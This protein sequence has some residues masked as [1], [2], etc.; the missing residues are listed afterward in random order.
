MIHLSETN[1]NNEE[2][3]LDRKNALCHVRAYDLLV[4]RPLL[5]SGLLAWCASAPSSTKRERN[6]TLLW[7]DTG[8]AQV[9][10]VQSVEPSSPLQADGDQSSLSDKSEWSTIQRYYLEPKKKEISGGVLIEVI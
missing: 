9:P 2:C 6:V 5:I 4:L 3:S 7:P 8:C 10:T 1:V